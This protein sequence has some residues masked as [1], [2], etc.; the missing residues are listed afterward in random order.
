LGVVSRW[1]RAASDW[2]SSPVRCFVTLA[3]IGGIAVVGL[4]RPRAPHD[5]DTHFFRAYAITEGHLTL[6]VHGGGVGSRLPVGVVHEF[7]TLH[8]DGAK[9]LGSAWSDWNDPTP[10][11][12]HKFVSYP[13]S[14]LSFVGHIPAAVGIAIGRAFGTS[15]FVMLL[16][17]RL[18][19]LLT[20]V[21][22]VAAA[23]RVVPVLRWPLTF[24]ALF[25]NVLFVA[26]VVSPDALIMASVIATIALMLYVRDRVRRSEPIPK[27]IWMAAIV[28]AILLGNAKAPYFLASAVWIVPLLSAPRRT[29]IACASV[30][31]LAI[32]IGMTWTVTQSDRYVLDAPA[33]VL[34]E[35]LTPFEALA[36]PQLGVLSSKDQWLELRQNPPSYGGAVWRMILHQ[37]GAITRQSFIDYPLWVPPLG[38]AFAGLGWL[39]LVR[40]ATEADDA[41]RFTGRERITLWVVLAVVSI[42]MTMSLWIY[43]TPYRQQ[44]PEI[45][46]MEGRYVIP[47]IPLL[48]IALPR[49]SRVAD[50]VR[51]QYLV[52]GAAALIGVA[53][54]AAARGEYPAVW[55]I[56]ERSPYAH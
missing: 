46:G 34:G 27:R 31:A 41:A 38:L 51:R 50:F 56:I 45:M 28:V 17:A 7:A 4:A 23:L 11:G 43:D 24:A 1:A 9:G 14:A 53:V 42:A 2:L 39:L 19:N 48:I 3:L 29:R 12:R 10:G 22:I 13:M 18:A 20:Y 6:E 8:L 21:A 35:R 40:F 25:P 47:L 54:F 30:G 52:I 15:L 32:V 5:E 36:A 49:W 55:R 26:A 37:G 33:G 44:N 16:L